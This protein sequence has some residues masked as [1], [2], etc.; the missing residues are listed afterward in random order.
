MNGEQIYYILKSDPFSEIIFKDVLPSDELPS[1]I[2]SPA[3]YVMNTQDH[4]L[5]GGHWTCLFKNGDKIEFFDS[6]GQT[7][8]YYNT[9]WIT[10]INR[11]ATKLEVNERIQDYNTNT[12]GLYCIYYSL[13][14]ARGCRMTDIV[15]LFYVNDLARNEEIIKSLLI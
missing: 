6:L 7:P 10:I 11:N 2:D 14:R 15:K 8:D 1:I 4:T 13:L 12:C 3:L 5:P 9:N